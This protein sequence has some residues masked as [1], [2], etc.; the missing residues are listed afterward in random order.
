MK[1]NTLNSTHSVAEPWFEKYNSR[2]D[3]KAKPDKKK[4]KLIRKKETAE[5]TIVGDNGSIPFDQ[6][7]SLENNIDS[8]VGT[9]FIPS[10]ANVTLDSFKDQVNQIK[11]VINEE[12]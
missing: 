1:K 7:I 6:T 4:K 9:I 11:T 2:K 10:K 12:N 8:L 5:P 3:Y